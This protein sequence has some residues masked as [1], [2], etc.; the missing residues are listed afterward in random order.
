MPRLL[1]TLVVLA[2]YALHQDVWF[3]RTPTPLVFGVLPIGLF[4]HA[5]YVVGA[6]ALMWLLVSRAWPARLEAD[7]HSASAGSVPQAAPSASPHE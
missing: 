7:L 4:Y 1:L 2:Y 3:W 6:S 5:C